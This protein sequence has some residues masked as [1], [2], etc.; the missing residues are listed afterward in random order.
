[1]KVYKQIYNTFF[2]KMYLRE[3]KGVDTKYTSY[4]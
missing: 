3:Q 1:M 2:S 4:H